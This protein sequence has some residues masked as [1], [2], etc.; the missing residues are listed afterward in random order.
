MAKREP[1]SAPTARSPGS[2]N[3]GAASTPFTSSTSACGW[4]CSRRWRRRRVEPRRGG[5]KARPACALRGGMVQDRL[6]HGAA[7]RGRRSALPA[8][9]TSMSSSPH[10][11]IRAIWVATC[12]SGPRWPRRTSCAV[13]R[14]SAPVRSSRSRAAA[15]RSTRPSPNPP[16]ACRWSRR[17]RSCRRSRVSGA[18]GSGRHAARGRLRHRQPAAA[19]RE[20]LSEGARGGRGHRGRQPG[21]RAQDRRKAGLEERV[22]ARQGTVASACSRAAWTPS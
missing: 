4:A 16:R 8:R 19:A 11:R 9:A 1:T 7:R 3:G 20:G 10:L 14:R 12:G 2:S 21:G 22:E 15:T 13:R 17:R 6:R 18:P 5:R